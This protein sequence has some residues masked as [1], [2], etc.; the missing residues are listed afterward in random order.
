LEDDDLVPVDD[1]QER[2]Q[3]FGVRDDLM[4]ANPDPLTG[5]VRQT[6]GQPL[7]GFDGLAE[8]LGHIRSVGTRWS[9]S[10]NKIAT[11]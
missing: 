8:R 5:E 10:C 3:R 11:I 2:R 4:V 7:L 9:R 1:L 6:L